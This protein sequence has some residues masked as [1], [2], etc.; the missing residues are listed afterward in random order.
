[1][2]LIFSKLYSSSN[3]RRLRLPY[4]PFISDEGLRYV[5]KKLPL[6]EELDISYTFLSKESIEAI[7]QGCPLLKVLKV[8]MIA[9]N[10]V[11]NIVFADVEAFAIAKSMPELR[12]L[13]IFGIRLTDKGLL[14]ILDGCPLLESLD[15]GHCSEVDLSVSLLKRLFEQVKEVQLPFGFDFEVNASDDSSSDGSSSDDNSDYSD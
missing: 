1:M 5:A 6:L 2:C 15:L 11:K 8:Q 12:H 7:G 13:Y 4:C 9:F 14:A 10:I 3:L